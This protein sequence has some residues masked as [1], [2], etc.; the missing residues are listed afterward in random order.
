VYRARGIK[1]KEEPKEPDHPSPEQLVA[2]HLDAPEAA[3]LQARIRRL[4]DVSNEH[5][6]AA[7]ETRLTREAKLRHWRLERGWKVCPRC[8]ATHMTTYTLCPICRIGG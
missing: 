5:A 8:L 4:S 3:E 7:V 6:R 1:R 2:V